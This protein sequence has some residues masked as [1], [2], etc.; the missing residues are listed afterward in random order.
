MNS[1]ATIRIIGGIYSLK[2]TNNSVVSITLDSG[3]EITSY[4]AEIS[5]SPVHLNEL[6][7]KTVSW[8]GQPLMPTAISNPC[9]LIG[10]A[11]SYVSTEFL[12]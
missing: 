4:E 9:G 11:A 7:G 8:K 2:T 5:C 1:R 6:M 3:R 10:T 12:Q